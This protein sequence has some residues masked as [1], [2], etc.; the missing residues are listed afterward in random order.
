V[1]AERWFRAVALDRLQILGLVLLMVLL[2]AAVFFVRERALELRWWDEAARNRVDLALAGADLGMWDWDV[3][4]DRIACC[5]RYAEMIGR[6]GGAFSESRAEIAARIHPEDLPGVTAVLEACLEGRSPAYE[7]EY[8]TRH[9]GGRWVWILSKGKVFARD[10]TGAPLRVVGTHLDVTE[11]RRADEALRRSK[12]DLERIVRARTEALREAVARAE[13]LA[14]Q[15]E[16]ANRAKS[17]FLARMSHE[18]RTP[19]G[20]VVGMIHLALRT[21]LDARQRDYLGKAR[22]A[23]EALLSLINDILDFSKIEAGRMEL[24]SIPFRIDQV[25]ESVAGVV[26]LRAEE[27]NLEI[28]FDRAPD[29]P[30]ALVGDPLRLGQVLIN[31]AGNAVKFTEAGEVLVSVGLAADPPEGAP[32][33]A[34]SVRLRFSVRDTGIGLTEEQ[35]E[36]LFRSFSQADESMARRYGGTGLGLAICKRLVEAMGGSIGVV[37]E[38]GRGSDFFFTA[39][40]GRATAEEVSREG[41]EGLPGAGEDA[42]REDRAGAGGSLP[43]LRDLRGERVLL[44]EPHEGARRVYRTALT[45]FGFAVEEA[46]SVSEAD[47]A[48]A[49]S[50]DGGRPFA[51]ALCEASLPDLLGSGVLSRLSGAGI[52]TVLLASYGGAEAARSA[53]ADAVLIKPVHRSALYDTLSDLLGGGIR[54]SL[55]PR[56]EGGEGLGA[57]R[58]A[59]ILLAEDNEINRQIARELLESAGLSVTEVSDG[60]RAVEAVERAFAGGVPFDLVLMDVQMPRMDGLQATRIIRA[61]EQQTGAHVP[62]IA[63]TAH[64]MKGDRERCIEAG[65]DD[66]VTKPVKEAELHEVIK[67]AV[68]RNVG[69]ELHGAS[70]AEARAADGAGRCVGPAEVSGAAELLTTARQAIAAGDC[71]AARTAIQALTKLDG[72][73]DTDAVTAIARE[74]VEALAGGNARLA[75]DLIKRLAASLCAVDEHADSRM[76]EAA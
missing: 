48:A 2:L 59:R 40:F 63:M 26:A 31:L 28:L 54:R 8:R 11:R 46:S 37:A 61:R 51:L 12:E 35:R 29:V 19:M 52:R 14:V 70:P 17:D 45:S 62:I 44:L 32:G 13:D 5:P 16:S 23:A 76:E 3:P 50:V 4:G 10:E 39:R 27:K 64:A 33:D 41:E 18:I 56:P 57:H 49:R 38:P 58:G 6:E 43:S 9:A 75:A 67:R 74:A 20:A 34:D 68:G 72:L 55:R 7:A 1:P 71:S 30:D 65:M 66:Y 25:L 73:P 15:A 69:T 21:R 42:A 53:P 22:N 47:R 24:E 60:E 36:R